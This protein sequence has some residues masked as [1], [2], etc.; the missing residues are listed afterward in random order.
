M[1]ARASHLPRSPQ[2]IR[3]R[4]VPTMEARMVTNS[5]P[6]IV[7]MS[8]RWDWPSKS[9]IMPARRGRRCLRRSRSRGFKA[10][11]EVSEMAKKMLS[12]RSRPR[13][14]HLRVTSKGKALSIPKKGG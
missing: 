2:S 8:R 1:T 6:R 3:A 12:T 14:S 11:R 7:V 5:T 4:E 10:K 9:S 13:E